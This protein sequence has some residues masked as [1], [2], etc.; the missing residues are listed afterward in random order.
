MINKTN[1]DFIDIVRGASVLRVLLV[2]LGLGW[3]WPPYSTYIG[4]FFPLLFFASGAVSY[5]SFLNASSLSV[6]S[7]KRIRSIVVPFIVF[8]IP[9]AMFSGNLDWFT[10]AAI[11]KW[12]L[13]TPEAHWFNFPI[14]HV[15]F[16]HCLLVMAFLSIVVFS[17]SKLHP[18]NLM[19]CFA[20]FAFLAVTA[21]FGFFSSNT[22][23]SGLPIS[24]YLLFETTSLSVFYFSGALFIENVRRVNDRLISLFGG[25]IIITWITVDAYSK[26]RSL[27]WFAEVRPLTYLMQSAGVIMLFVG[28]RSYIV[29]LF[30]TLPWLKHFVMY[31]NKHAFSAFMLHIPILEFVEYVF[32]WHDLSGNVVLALTRMVVVIVLTAVVCIPLTYLHKAVSNWLDKRVLSVNFS[33]KTQQS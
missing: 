4:I 1:R 13:L 16:I 26:I 21:D 15:W 25:A 10:V 22:F 28:L 18:Q 29:S 7:Y 20:F 23:I 33:N 6:Y 19:I 8:M 24:G 5:N 27:E 31:F 14:G 12:L 17:L 2:H 9:A 32:G 11:P 30:V 3:F